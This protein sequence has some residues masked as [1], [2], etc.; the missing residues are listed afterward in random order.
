MQVNE[1]YSLKAL[2][3][4]GI[5]ATARY[6]SVFS[7]V[8]TLQEMAGE[9]KL[10]GVNKMILGGGSNILF[11]RN[12]DGWVLK[13]D[14][15]GIEK[16]AEDEEHIYVKT[17]AGE[18]W[19][20]FVMYCIE[21]GYAGVENL[22]LIPGNTGA[23]PMQNIGAYGVEIKDVFH[24][25][26]AFDL[27]DKNVVRFSLADCAFG[28]RESIF[29]KK[30]KGRFVIL[31]VTYRLNKHPLFNVSY[32][33][34]EKELEAM[35]VRE[36]SIRA[37]SQAVINIRSSRLPDPA[38]I[39]NA[40]SFFKNPEVSKEKFD[41]LKAGFEQIA[42]YPLENGCYK[43]AAGWLIEQCG[44]K[45]FREGDAGVHA[46]QALV[47]VN[48]GYASGKDI[49]DLSQ[50]ILESVEEKFG[51]ILEREVNIVE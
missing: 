17:G 14:I 12:F 51:V 15:S 39:G 29:K 27:Q 26:E 38:K 24:E 7:S 37:I 34:I 8:A 50:W 47:L 4:F 21:K 11:T 13:N 46:R 20:R 5:D 44:W 1:N 23:S 32:G 31:S 25:L 6:F 43:L 3:T 36:L 19:H 22:S 30:Y 9:P 49:Y 2:N 42:A 40:G 10:A 35:G 28:Y 16:I 33:A 48:Y 41:Q 18:N 45:G